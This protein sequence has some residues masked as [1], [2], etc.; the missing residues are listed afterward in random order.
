MDKDKIISK[1]KDSFNKVKETSKQIIT[2][3]TIDANY[4]KESHRFK[5]L[6]EDDKTKRYIFSIFDISSNVMYFKEIDIIQ[7]RK[8]IEVNDVLKNKS[9]DKFKVVKIEDKMFD[10]L[11]KIKKGYKTISCYKVYLEKI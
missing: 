9:N 1:V 6:K 4:I 2:Q 8:H 5:I 7:K 3:S 11:L 10:Y